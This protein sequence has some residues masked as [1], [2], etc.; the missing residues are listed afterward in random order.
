MHRLMIPRVLLPASIRY[1]NV[2]SQLHN[3]MRAE[4]AMEIK[5]QSKNHGLCLWNELKKYGYKNI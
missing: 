5:G 4:L 2:V 3:D 1:S